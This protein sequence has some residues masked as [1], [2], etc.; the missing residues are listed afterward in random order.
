MRARPHFGCTRLHRPGA[1]QPGKLDRFD[2]TLSFPS[3]LAR[4]PEGRIQHD[5][6]LKQK[7]FWNIDAFFGIFIAI[8]LKLLWK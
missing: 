8:F 5:H 6:S 1:G 3:M 7:I 4:N 2:G